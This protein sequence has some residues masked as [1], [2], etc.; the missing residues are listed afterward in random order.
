MSDMSFLTAVKAK[1]FLHMVITFISGELAILA[2]FVG[3]RVLRLILRGA[4]R[5]FRGQRR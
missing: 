3:D 1:S 2:Q 5:G 4:F